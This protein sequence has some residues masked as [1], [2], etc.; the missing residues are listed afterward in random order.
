MRLRIHRA[1]IPPA[2]KYVKNE[3]DLT[4]FAA[5][6]QIRTVFP[7]MSIEIITLWEEEIKENR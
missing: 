1:C 7:T 6:K 3:N 2:W 5:E 4:L